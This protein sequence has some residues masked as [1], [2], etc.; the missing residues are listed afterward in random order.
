MARNADD[1]NFVL[2]KPVR[3][4]TR[5]CKIDLRDVASMAWTAAARCVAYSAPDARRASRA[6]LK[7][8]TATASHR[9]PTIT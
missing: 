1:E 7:G 8:A 9:V 2:A 4:P 3:M 6:L 5:V